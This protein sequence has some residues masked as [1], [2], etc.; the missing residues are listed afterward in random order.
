MP[1]LFDQVNRLREVLVKAAT[2]T[3]FEEIENEYA[4]LR[5]YLLEETQVA[6]K[7]PAFVYSCRKLSGFWDFIK[8]QGS[9]YAERREFLKD[10]FQDILMDLELGQHSPAEKAALAILSR[11]DSENVQQYWQKALERRNTDPEGAI[12]MARTLLEAVCRFVLDQNQVEHDEK[13]DLP[14]LYRMTAEELN[15]APSQHTEEIFKQILG[16][17]QAVVGGLAA[18]RNRLS[19]AHAINV[20]PSQRH[21]KLA[22]NLAGTMSTFIVDTFEYRKVSK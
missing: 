11:V 19:D 9:T 6:E 13:F 20:K 22:V 8:Q 17:C 7:L 2:G 10:A 16:A 3:R 21:A 4:E 15:L 14:K 1:R 5:S 18:I 12:T